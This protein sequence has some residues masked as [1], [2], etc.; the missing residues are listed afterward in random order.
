MSARHPPV[1]LTDVWLPENGLEV[2]WS[3]RPARETGRR[4]RRVA[5][6]VQEQ[7][8]SSPGLSAG[9]GQT[10][11][12]WKGLSK[13][14]LSAGSRWGPLCLAVLILARTPDC[15]GGPFLA[16]SYGFLAK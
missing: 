11:T 4:E 14:N 15:W 3:L 12:L 10:P 5:R 9:P 2:S 7:P 6:Q 16:V 1:S 13:W 8:S